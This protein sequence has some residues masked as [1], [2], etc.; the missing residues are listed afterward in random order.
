M[1]EGRSK[2][3]PAEALVALRQ[4][5]DALPT[6]HPERKA[7]LENAASLYGISRATLYRAVQQQWRPRPARRADHGRPRKLS[8]V[9]LERACE[10]IAALKLRTTNKTGRHLSTNRTIE[11]LE[12]EGVDTPDSLL[13]LAPG[14]LTRTTANRY[15]RRWGYDHARITREP[16]AARFQAE[17]SNALW[18][19]D[20]SPSD[21]KQ[22]P[23]PLWSEPGR[24]ATSTQGARC[25][26]GGWKAVRTLRRRLAAV[27]AGARPARASPSARRSPRRNPAPPAPRPP[28][29]R[30]APP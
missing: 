15:L 2:R 8:A 22:V 10:G 9:E 7:L 6:R 26:H 18:Q 30:P 13:R 19:F 3:L 27:T 16:A 25:G 14:T 23:A 17:H 1:A 20:M 11:L 12:G 5:L 4:R 24:G 21:L 28:A 29:A